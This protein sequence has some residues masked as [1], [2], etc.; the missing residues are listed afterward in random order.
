M[1]ERDKALANYEITSICST[2][3]KH[4]IT[5][6][7]KMKFFT[8]PLKGLIFIQVFPHQIENKP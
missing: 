7:R 3:L 5:Y 1:R 6:M 2:L 4:I 8:P